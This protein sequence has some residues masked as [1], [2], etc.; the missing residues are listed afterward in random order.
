LL[1]QFFTGELS[2]G[3][4][5][6]ETTSETKDKKPEVFDDTLTRY[7]RF[8][9]IASP[10]KIIERTGEV[11]KTLGLKHSSRDAYKVKVESGGLSFIAQVFSDSKID[12]QYVVDFRKIKG[13]GSE[14]RSLYQE[15]RAHLADIVLQP[16]QTEQDKTIE[17][18]SV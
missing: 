7:T 14:F 4:E 1:N 9:S 8:N 17:V 3:D 2:F 11:L 6:E 18:D 10:S 12:D 5:E 15:I 16:K 13:D